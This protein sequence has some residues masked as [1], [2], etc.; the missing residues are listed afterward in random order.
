MVKLLARGGIGQ[1]MQAID[2]ELN[3]EVAVKEIQS[4]LVDDI[5]VRERFLREAEITGQ[6][7]HPGIVPVY[8]LG[9]DEQERPFYAMRLVRGQSLLEAI[10]DFHGSAGAQ[11]FRSLQFSESP[12]AILKRM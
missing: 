7:E 11:A 8:G 4:Q 6:L 1:V 2:T 3:R 9:S 10:K 5:A 12:A